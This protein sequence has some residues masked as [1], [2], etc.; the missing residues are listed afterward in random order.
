MSL[1]HES[2]NIELFSSLEFIFTGSLLKT[3]L[4]LNMILDNKYNRE[5]DV[6]YA[7]LYSYITL[8]QK[9]RNN[10][11]VKYY[12]NMIVMLVV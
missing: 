10:P 11:L 8:K 5:I 1:T 4:S 12:S 9:K 7:T 3:N 2:R 6:I